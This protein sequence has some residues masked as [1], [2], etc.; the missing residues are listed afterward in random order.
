MEQKTE[1]RAVFAC[2]NIKS[3]KVVLQFE[4]DGEDRS[5]LPDLAVMTGGAV[6]ISVG[7]AQQVL[8]VDAETG[9]LV[10]D[11]GELEAEEVEA[12][13]IEEPDSWEVDDAYS[14]PAG[15][16]DDAA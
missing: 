4:L 2:C 10:D 9:E 15:A 8:F 14:L 11:A 1:V 13:D 16:D 6:V 7:N 5:K 3:G 12:D